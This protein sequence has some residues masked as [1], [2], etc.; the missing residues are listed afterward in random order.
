MRMIAFCC[1]AL[2]VP[3]STPTRADDLKFDE[4]ILVEGKRRDVSVLYV[5]LTEP[6]W[7]APQKLVQV[8]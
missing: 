3:F 4:V 7:S 5:I 2:A 1:F 8:V 6:K